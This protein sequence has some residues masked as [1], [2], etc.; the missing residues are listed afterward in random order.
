MYQNYQYEVDPKDPFKPLNQA[1][2]R[3][4]ICCISRRGRAPRRQVCWFCRRTARQRMTCGVRAVG[5]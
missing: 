2:K 5:V 3:A 1:A 4:G